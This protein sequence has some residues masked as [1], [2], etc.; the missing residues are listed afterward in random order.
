MFTLQPVFKSSRDVAV[1]IH[2]LTI[3]LNLNP[4]IFEN[5]LRSVLFI[6]N[7]E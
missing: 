1:S 5:Y 6:G 4:Q 3:G 2:S 7:F